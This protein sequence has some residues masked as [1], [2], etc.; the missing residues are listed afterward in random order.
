MTF[1][2]MKASLRAARAYLYTG[3]QPAS[4]TLGL[5]EAMMT[6]IPVVSIGPEHMTVFSYGPSLFEGHEIVSSRTDDWHWQPWSDD[7][8]EARDKLSALLSSPSY[9]QEQSKVQRARAIELF[10]KERIAAEWQAFL[11]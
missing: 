4:Y 11:G 5:I 7:P 1:G 2:Q 3:T 6:G 8:V 10:G 9:A